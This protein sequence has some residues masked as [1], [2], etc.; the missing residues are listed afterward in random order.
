MPTILVIE[1]EASL[2]EQIVEIL[3]LEAF[4]VLEAPDGKQ[5]SELA[6]QTRPD[7]ILCD[8]AMPNMDGYAVLEAIRGN[9][10]VA[11]T[12]FIFLTARVDRSFVR[13]GM[14]LG[15]DD[16]LTKP[17]SHAELLAAIQSRL[18]HHAQ[19]RNSTQTVLEKAQKRLTRMVAHELRTPVS[20]IS[21]VQQLISQRLDSLDP[22]ELKEL[23]EILDGGSTR[24]RHLVEQMVLMTQLELGVI[25]AENIVASQGISDISS[26]ITSAINLAREFAHRHKTSPINL[27]LPDE[28]IILLVHS[29]A[30]RHALAEIIANALDFSPMNAEIQVFIRKLET[31]VQINIVDQGQGLTTNRLRLALRP[32]EQVGR[33]QTEQQG[34]GL[35]LPLAV[36]I[37][38][39]H[40]GKLDFAPTASGGTKISIELPAYSTS[41]RHE[42]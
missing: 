41:D 38:K 36:K 22:V 12:P 6:I 40:G 5:G 32:F 16:Y 33:E 37:I 21:M 3:S 31:K 28:T 13:H 14:E 29:Q 15:A 24:L 26:L 35:G 1:D 9:E 19:L 2:R 18:K 4:T 34:M 23:L 25:S 30:L 42:E 7:L 39:T 17:F 27:K 8:I 11:T 10:A 20:A